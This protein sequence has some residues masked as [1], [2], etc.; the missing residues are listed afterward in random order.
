MPN[1]RTSAGSSVPAPAH[2]QLRHRTCLVVEGKVN[3]SPSSSHIL[4]LHCE[5]IAYSWEFACCQPGLHHRNTQ[6]HLSSNLVINNALHCVYFA[7]GFS[8]F[9]IC[10]YI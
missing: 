5:G 8:V 3:F 6:N 9:F 2:T 4:G 1:C 10:V 7:D